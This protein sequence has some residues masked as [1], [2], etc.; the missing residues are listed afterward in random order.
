MSWY[1]SPELGRNV[2]NPAKIVNEKPPPPKK[3]KKKKDP[4]KIFKYRKKKGVM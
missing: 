1:W 3:K 2:I 4:L